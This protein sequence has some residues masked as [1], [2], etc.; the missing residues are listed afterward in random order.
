MLLYHERDID[1]ARYWLQNAEPN[2]LV[3]DTFQ[4]SWR[5][6]HDC[7]IAICQVFKASWS[8]LFYIYITPTRVQ[9]DIKE[10]VAKNPHL[11]PDDLVVRELCA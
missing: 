3:L 6:L 4:D 1:H 8:P 7:E 5:Y 9:N 2:V 10:A 11:K